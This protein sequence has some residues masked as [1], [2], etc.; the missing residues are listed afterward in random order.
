MMFYYE[1]DDYGWEY[2]P[3][4]T[5]IEDAVAWIIKTTYPELTNHELFDTLA[6]EI[7]IDTNKYDT[8]EIYN[9]LDLL[10]RTRAIHYIITE[11]D[12]TQNEEFMESCKEELK[13]YFA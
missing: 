7:G 3:T 1:H 9:K 12:L 6:S 5:E 11:L 8:K 13:E 2:E 10:D 4:E